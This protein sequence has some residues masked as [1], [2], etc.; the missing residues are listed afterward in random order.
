MKQEYID[1]P[2]MEN[3]DT[4]GGFEDVWDMQSVAS[5]HSMFHLT[6]PD[7]QIDEFIEKEESIAALE[8]AW[9]ETIVEYV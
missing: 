7:K 2:K 6:H 4:D 3:Y 1:D 5:S 8:L 9:K